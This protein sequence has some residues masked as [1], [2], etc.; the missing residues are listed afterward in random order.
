MSDYIKQLIDHYY[1]L[2]IRN[3]RESVPKSMAFNFVNKLKSIRGHVLI[4]IGQ[5]KDI[6]SFLDE[7]PMIVSKRKYHYDILKILEKSEKIMSSDEE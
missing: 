6:E 5:C 4:E 7:D 2:T 3:L 1:T